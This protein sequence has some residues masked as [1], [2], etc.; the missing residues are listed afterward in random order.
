MDGSLVSFSF[1]QSLEELVHVSAHCDLCNIYVAVGHSDFSKVLLADCLTCCR[2]L[3][4]L[5]DVGGLGSLSAGVGVN[6]GIEY[7]DV[8]VFTGSDNVVE[9]A[10]ADIVSPAVATEDP[11]GLLSEVILFSE[12]FG[13]DSAAGS[14][15]LFKLSDESLGCGRVSLAVVLGVKVCLSSSLELV[16]SLFG[17][18]S[19]LQP[20]R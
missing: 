9:T 1:R 12:D 11:D 8:Y 13:S 18:A 2:E 4:N 15:S 5:T 17:A 16:G 14:S 10:E 6:F 3:S 7:H 19:S 20:C